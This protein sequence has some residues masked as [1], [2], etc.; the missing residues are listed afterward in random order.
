MSSAG[1]FIDGAAREGAGDVRVIV[2]PASAEAVAEVREGTAAD[3]SAATAAARGAFDEW[4]GRTPGERARVL[5]RLADLIEADVDELTRLE[6]A[7]TGKPRA[8]FA[9]GEVPFAA[10]NLRFFAGSASCLAEGRNRNGPMV[11]TASSLFS[12]MRNW[13]RTRASSSA[14]RNGLAM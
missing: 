3:V 6:V 1:V 5:L 14:R 10:D 2:D 11:N 7:E 12:N 8:V 9:D 13:A 4:S